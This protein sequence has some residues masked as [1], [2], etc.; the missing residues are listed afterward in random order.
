IAGAAGIALLGR[1]EGDGPAPGSTAAVPP[2]VPAPAAAPAPVAAAP[3]PLPAESS[4][5]AGTSAPPPAPPRR[6]PA[7]ER[8]PAE[9]G[10][11]AGLRKEALEV[12]A[13]ASAAGAA[14]AALSAGDSALG[15]ADS[16]A[17][18][19]RTVEAASR[20][21]AA[22]AVWSKAGSRPLDTFRIHEPVAVPETPAAESA[23]ARRPVATPAPVPAP[24]PAAPPAAPSPPAD[25]AREIGAV[26]ERYARAIEARSLPAI[27]QVYPAIQPAQARDWEQFFEAVRQIGVDL[28]ITK[29]D[30]SGATAQAAVAGT[31]QFEDPSTRRDRRED[32]SFVARLRREGSGWSIESIR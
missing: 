1:T 24:A 27:R 11:I 23:P 18:A 31:Y 22:V 2:P 30:V 12:R 19:G 9:S 10:V 32:V 28:R 26:F 13:R 4:T 8:R 29:L 16:L 25:P 7:A 3:E 14:P 5:A 20:L 15:Q 6:Q 17:R 21:S